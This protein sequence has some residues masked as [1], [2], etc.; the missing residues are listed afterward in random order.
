MMSIEAMP[1]KIGMI[2]LQLINHPMGNPHRS[3]VMLLV[4]QYSITNELHAE[5]A[6]TDPEVQQ[7]QKDVHEVLNLDESTDIAYTDL[8]DSLTARQ[9]HDKGWPKGMTE[10]LYI[11]IEKEAFRLTSLG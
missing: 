6:E 11:R 7:L 3:S 9:F 10:E 2:A 5:Q 1:V 4:E 8:Y